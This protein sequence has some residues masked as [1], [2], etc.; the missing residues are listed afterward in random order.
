MKTKDIL[1]VLLLAAIVVGFSISLESCHDPCDDSKR[2]SAEFLTYN[3]LYYY[4]KESGKT[5]EK[6]KI[7]EED[8]FM[9]DSYVYFEAIDQNA[10][11][12]EWTIG[13]DPKKRTG[14]KFSLLFQDPSI[15][16]E[17]PI[18]VKL[19]IEKAPDSKCFP[20]DPGIDSVTHFIYFLPKENLPI[21]GKYNGAD[22]TDPTKTFTIEIYRG[23]FGEII[24]K[25]LP[26][27]CNAPNKNV[28]LK[29][30]TAFEFVLETIPTTTDLDCYFRD[31]DKKI[32]SLLPD[33][34]SIVI[35][36]EFTEGGINDSQKKHRVFKGKRI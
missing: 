22:D 2:V 34:R 12:Y 17:N 18:P 5:V 27:A 9:I 4:D 36:Y 23:Q 6:T 10:E 7:V 1:S 15:P 13:S 29:L 35:D 21:L 32:G 25:N 20:N 24:I 30:P 26:N 3:G 19:K 11:S 31:L 14:K 33:R 8:T 28:R 16:Q